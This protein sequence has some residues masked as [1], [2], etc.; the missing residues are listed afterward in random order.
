MKKE[1]QSKEEFFS[2]Y[3]DDPQ[4]IKLFSFDETGMDLWNN[5]VSSTMPTSMPC[6]VFISKQIQISS[7]S[8][9]SIAR[10]QYLRFYRILWG[11][12]NRKDTSILQFFVFITQ[13]GYDCLYQCILLEKYG[14][15]GSNV[16]IFD[17]GMRF[18]HQYSRARQQIVHSKSN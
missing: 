2:Q 16:I 17:M 11:I 15:L 7:L 10:N 14:G 18:M 4:A 3:K 9:Y 8:A 12:K 5:R 13:W 6:L 1:K